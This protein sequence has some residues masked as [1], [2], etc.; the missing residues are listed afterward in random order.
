ME[1]PRFVE[2]LREVLALPSAIFEGPTFG[3]VDASPK[4]CFEEVSNANYTV[5]HRERGQFFRSYAHKNIE[6]FKIISTPT[7]SWI[8]SHRRPRQLPVG[9]EIILNFSKFS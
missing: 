2:Y 9:V 5:S 6:N 1:Y 8:R 4:Q 7:G 3:F